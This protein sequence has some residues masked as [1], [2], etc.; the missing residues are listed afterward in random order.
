MAVVKI[1]EENAPSRLRSII[2]CLLIDSFNNRMGSARNVSKWTEI[3]CI[4]IGTLE[5][6]TVSPYLSWWSVNHCGWKS[7]KIFRPIFTLIQVKVLTWMQPFKMSNC[8][9]GCLWERKPQHW[10]TRFCVIFKHCE[11]LSK[12]WWIYETSGVSKNVYG[13][14]DNHNF[15]KVFEVLLFPTFPNR[16]CDVA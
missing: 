2:F 12:N 7:S 1:M 14:T 8:F 3:N 5:S 11:V 9:Y 6:K 4:A 15:A 16:V 10:K 13:L